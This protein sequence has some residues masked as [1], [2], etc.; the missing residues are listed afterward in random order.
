[1][2]R[3]S[4]RC[5]NSGQ[6]WFNCPKSP[7][8]K[9]ACASMLSPRCCNS[10]DNCVP[11]PGLMTTRSE[12]APASCNRIACAATRSCARS[13]AS[14][15]T[16]AAAE[17]GMMFVGESVS[18]TDAATAAAGAE[19]KIP[20]ARMARRETGAEEFCAGKFCSRAAKTAPPGK[21]FLPEPAISFVCS[22]FFICTSCLA[23]VVP[24][25]DTAGWTGIL[26]VKSGTTEIFTAAESPAGGGAGSSA[27]LASTESVFPAAMVWSDCRILSVEIAGGFAPEPWLE[28][29]GTGKQRFGRIDSAAVRCR[30]KSA[31]P[32]N[33]KWFRPVFLSAAAKLKPTK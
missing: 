18:L 14:E 9:T 12:S 11:A 31:P 29:T 33:L 24:C 28:F 17:K 15:R 4:S 22:P 30:R 3:C 25:S 23:T 13:A 7:R 32:A 27:G 1:M 19:L 6:C 10:S 20:S 2:P 21:T 8:C 16:S 5:C 26:A